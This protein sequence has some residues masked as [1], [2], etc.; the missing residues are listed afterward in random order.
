M[1]LGLVEI[2]KPCYVTYHLRIFI[3][4][5][6]SNDCMQ[7]KDLNLNK[8]DMLTG[9]I[10]EDYTNWNTGMGHTTI[11]PKDVN[12]VSVKAKNVASKS[13]RHK[14]KLFYSLLH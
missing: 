14:V 13:S 7:F 5:G 12:A 8:V 11:L 9:Q 4:N 2:F 1:P 6:T 10:A 3:K